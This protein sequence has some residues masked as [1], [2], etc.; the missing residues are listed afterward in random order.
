MGRVENLKSVIEDNQDRKEKDILSKG[1]S[2]GTGKEKFIRTGEDWDVDDSG[3]L[4]YQVFINKVIK[5]KNSD[6]RKSNEFFMCGFGDVHRQTYEY[7]AIST[8]E[9]ELYELMRSYDAQEGIIGKFNKKTQTVKY[10]VV[11][12]FTDGR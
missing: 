7:G 9:S 5:T 10:F 6:I 1:F 2:W 11:Y 8:S 12:P 3:D 4:D